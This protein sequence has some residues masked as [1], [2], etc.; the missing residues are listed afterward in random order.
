MA[1]VAA[2]F[3]VRIF[4][5]I[6]PE[7]LSTLETLC[8]IQRDIGE[9]ENTA[10]EIKNVVTS[11]LNAGYSYTDLPFVQ[12]YLAIGTAVAA[13]DVVDQP[14][15]PLLAAAYKLVR[16]IDKDRVPLNWKNSFANP[17]AYFQE[18]SD[19]LSTYKTALGNAIAAGLANVNDLSGLRL[20]IPGASSEPRGIEIGS[21]LVAVGQ[22]STQI[23]ELGNTFTFTIDARKLNDAQRNTLKTIQENDV[24][25][26]RVRRPGESAFTR[27]FM[28][29]ITS[30]EESQEY[31]ALNRI[32]FNCYSLSKLLG[33]ST[34]ISDP[35]FQSQFEGILPAGIESLEVGNPSIP[36]FADIFNDKNAGQ[37]FDYIVTNFLGLADNQKLPLTN[38]AQKAALQTAASNL[39]DLLAQKNTLYNRV[40]PL[41]PLLPLPPVTDPLYSVAVAQREEDQARLRQL[42]VEIAAAQLSVQNAE[43]DLQNIDE[44]IQLLQK[45]KS[46]KAYGFDTTRFKGAPNNFQ[47]ATYLL[48]AFYLARL[49]DPTTS[50]VALLEGGD[51]RVFNLL[52]K[53]G[54][55]TWYSGLQSA[56]SVLDTLRTTAFY[57]VFEDRQ[58]TLH[59]RPGK[60]NTLSLADVSNVGWPNMSGDQVISPEDVLNFRRVRQDLT[61]K[62]R[63]DYQMMWPFADGAQPWI[64]GHY[65]DIG[66]LIQYG[67]RVDAPTSNP[68]V[69]NGETANLFSALDWA[70]KTRTARRY[71]VQV[72]N[73]RD[74]AVGKL[75]YF[76]TKDEEGTTSDVVS[77]G[78]VGYLTNLESGFTYGDVLTHTLTL[79]FVRKAEIV[80][81]PAETIGR[82]AGNDAYVANYRKLPDLEQLILTLE[83]NPAIAVKDV[84]QSTSRSTG[85][86]GDAMY[87]GISNGYYVVKSP[88]SNDGSINYN[89]N[90]LTRFA[91][92]AHVG[93]EGDDLM[94]NQ[95]AAHLHLAD[96]ITP[97]SYAPLT[98]S[99]RNTNGLH[100]LIVR[101]L[102]GLLFGNVDFATAGVSQTDPGTAYFI[103]LST[104]PGYTW[105]RYES[106]PTVPGQAA[107][108]QI[109]RIAGDSLL[110]IIVMGEKLTTGGDSLG[111]LAKVIFIRVPSTKALTLPNIFN[112]IYLESGGARSIQ[113][114]KN[115]VGEDGAIN[116]P[117]VKGVAHTFAPWGIERF[118]PQDVANNM[119]EF[120]FVGPTGTPGIAGST[121]SQATFEQ[122]FAN[123]PGLTAKASTQLLEEAKVAVINAPRGFKARTA[124]ATSSANIYQL[125]F[126]PSTT[127]S[128]T[129]ALQAVA[130]LDS[131]TTTANHL[132]RVTIN[133]TVYY[134][135]IKSI[136]DL[137]PVTSNVKVTIRTGRASDSSAGDLP[138]TTPGLLSRF[139]ALSLPKFVFRGGINATDPYNLPQEGDIYEVIIDELFTLVDASTASGKKRV[140]RI[141]EQAS[142][143]TASSGKADRPPI[144]GNYFKLLVQANQSRLLTPLAKFVNT[145]LPGI[146]N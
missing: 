52:V 77:A 20:R 22:L 115:I 6:R 75:Y 83:E 132:T 122:F 107:T 44:Q 50:I 116:D 144:Y 30:I 108:I 31:G 1:T 4:Q 57:E 80:K 63:V 73:N 103:G 29:F 136:Q 78:V 86:E 104:A 112:S 74:Y 34:I 14:A 102:S 119:I 143:A 64:G 2:Q 36:V 126:V 124:V 146:T 98:W 82:V 91:V 106:I 41:P 85:L 134:S 66:A 15:S 139:I 10:G 71:T 92:A 60:Y 54:H 42:D 51:S 65:T 133:P 35:A 110:R 49:A 105:T 70:Y 61:I 130:A 32:T 3:S 11:F 109:D 58:G 38:A 89:N 7:S 19:T 18:F 28:G 76:P 138:T 37:I 118:I 137:A 55:R 8:R 96:L 128:F 16:N 81:I 129:S 95:L 111:R 45:N 117:H 48:Y 94:Q 97:V 79:D 135:F 12:P 68:N 62:T 141:P 56:S 131:S 90:F 87:A 93:T 114:S 113:E 40:N 46:L 127:T 121:V 25:E 142:T 125:T 101:T 123:T 88:T 59:C 69:Q 26:F 5:L 21:A 120:D 47:I 140:S 72:V 27:N 100:E 9:L 99:Y 84:A 43:T 17:K 53:R 145:V 39:G 24:V 23:D 13:T 67:L 33:I